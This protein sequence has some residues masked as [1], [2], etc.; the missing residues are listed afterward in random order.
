MSPFRLSRQSLHRIVTR[1][2]LTPIQDLCRTP[3]SRRCM[4][5]SNG[6]LQQ[7]AVPAM[8]C[9][10]NGLYQQWAVAGRMC[11][12]NS[13]GMGCAIRHRECHRTLC[14]CVHWLR[15]ACLFL[16]PCSNRFGLGPRTSEVRQRSQ[17]LF[18]FDTMFQS[19]WA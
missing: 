19:F 16:I 14:M 13:W 8:G 9:T 12:S 2:I 17:C 15:I 18:I 5:S 4:C 11:S 6:L 3:T 1:P 10:S 7:W